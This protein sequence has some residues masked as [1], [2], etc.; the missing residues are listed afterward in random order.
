MSKSDFADRAALLSKMKN[1]NPDNFVESWIATRILK[2]AGLKSR[3]LREQAATALGFERPPKKWDLA[4][5]VFN[6][7]HIVKYQLQVKLY[8]EQARTIKSAL[9]TIR[10]NPWHKGATGSVGVAVRVNE[11]AYLCYITAGVHIN[12]LVTPPYTVYPFDS[13]RHMV[14]VDLEKQMEVLNDALS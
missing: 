1:D 13:D 3:Q 6:K 10:S 9:D 8:V 12:D 5:S 2:G 7:M 4:A 14:V 11:K